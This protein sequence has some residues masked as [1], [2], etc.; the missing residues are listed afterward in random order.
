M[1]VVISL[2]LFLASGWVL[3]GMPLTLFPTTD[4]GQISINMNLPPG[5]TIDTTNKLAQQVESVVMAQPEVQ[6]AVQG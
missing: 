4:E 2:A 3:R 1:I 5:N 6:R